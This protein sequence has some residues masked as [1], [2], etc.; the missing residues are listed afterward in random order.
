MNTTRRALIL[1]LV[2]FALGLAAALLLWAISDR[3]PII[4]LRADLGTW[5]ALLGG[6]LSLLALTGVVVWAVAGRRLDQTLTEARQ[7]QAE[8]HRR[9]LRQL[10][11]ELKNPLTAI[12]IGLANLAG[13]PRGEARDRT[14]AGV[15]GQVGRLSK[16]ATDLRKLADLETQP[17][18]RAAVDLSELLSEVV[19]LARQRPE[20]EEREIA[21]ALPQAP[22]PLPQVPG[23]RDLLFLAVYN[24]LDNALKFTRP[25][26]TI[27]VRAVE[28]G[29]VVTVEIA[30]TGPGIPKDELSH[31][32][33]ELYRGQGARGTEG[34]GLGLALV[35]TIVERHGGT[36][37]VRSREGEGTV[38]TLHL[39]L[40]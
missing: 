35:R 36:V 14:L 39:P 31:V 13:T 7:A 12:C 38:F 2:P 10:D 29:R 23:D 11:H 32:F 28:D 3:L 6:L 37:T 27:E 34:S 9:F 4:R 8:A 19:A 33:E 15:E 18:E 25:S 17:L 5:L 22:W 1:A 21:L 16:L 24:L 40:D 30:D 26:D 20:G